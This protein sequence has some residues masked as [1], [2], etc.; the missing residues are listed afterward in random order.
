MLHDS[1]YVEIFTVERDER[2]SPEKTARLVPKAAQC[3]GELTVGLNRFYSA[4]SVGQRADKLIEIWRDDTVTT[5][6]VARINGRYYLI[7]QT[8]NAED[9]DGLLV[10]RLT[11]EETDGNVWEGGSDVEQ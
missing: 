3:F 7:Q 5:R 2:S 4:A 8:A 10:T 1:G 11:L 9:K 6:D